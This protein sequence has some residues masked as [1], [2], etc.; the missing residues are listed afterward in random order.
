M[1]DDSYLQ[2]LT[3]N[4]DG[5]YTDQS[6]GIW[7]QADLN[8]YAAIQDAGATNPTGDASGWLTGSGNELANGPNSSQSLLPSLVNGVFGMGQSL[9]HAFGPNYSQYGPN[10]VPQNVSASQGRVGVPVIGSVSKNGLMIGAAIVGLV[11]VV[12]FMDKKK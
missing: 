12:M 7:T 11:L 5:T 9:V 2:T 10:G 3:D 4:G 1:T 8:Q 6:G